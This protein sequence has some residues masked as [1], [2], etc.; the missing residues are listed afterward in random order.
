MLYMI[1]FFRNAVVLQLPSKEPL[2][3][4]PKPVVVPPFISTNGVHNANQ[5]PQ[6][7]DKKNAH[8]LNSVVKPTKLDDEQNMNDSKIL[9]DSTFTMRF[10]NKI[11]NWS[12]S[13]AKYAR[14]SIFGCKVSIY[15][16]YK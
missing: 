8:I 5:N 13:T 16:L 3:R 1:E 11:E 4:D 2:K 10:V 9:D 7:T 14:L 12:P 6:S 15:H